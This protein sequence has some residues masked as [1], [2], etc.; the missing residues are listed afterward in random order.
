MVWPSPRPVA[1][2]RRSA[3]PVGRG[4]AGRGLKMAGKFEIYKSRRQVPHRQ[5]LE[6]GLDSP[7]ITTDRSVWTGISKSVV[8]QV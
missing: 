1:S 7:L 8:P 6:S 4:R 2:S 3:Y 5:G